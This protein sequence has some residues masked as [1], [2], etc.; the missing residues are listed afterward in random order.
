MINNIWMNGY[1]IHVEF[2]NCAREYLNIRSVQVKL[3]SLCASRSCAHKVRNKSLS[4]PLEIF[5]SWWS[6]CVNRCKIQIT[7]IR[8]PC[9]EKMIH[10]MA[11]SSRYHYLMK[12][13]V[14]SSREVFYVFRKSS[15]FLLFPAAFLMSRV[16]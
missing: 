16:T 9:I 12:L 8:R 11:H 2:D 10:V 5:F 14:I 15:V 6:V 7:I 1:V 13:V 3:F 4:S